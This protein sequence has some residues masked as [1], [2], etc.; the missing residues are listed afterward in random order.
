MKHK[1]RGIIAACLCLVL[2]LAILF[3]AFSEK[4]MARLLPE[5]TDTTVCMITVNN[6]P[7]ESDSVYLSHMEAVEPLV[8]LLGDCKLRFSG[9]VG[10]TFYGDGATYRL[11]FGKGDQDAGSLTICGTDVYSGH[12]Y[13]RMSEEDGARCQDIL[14]QAMEKGKEDTPQP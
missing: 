1:R 11:V 7:T 12:F 14:T 4:S 8:T 5:V 9:F 3:L 13:F 10:S 6:P 2:A